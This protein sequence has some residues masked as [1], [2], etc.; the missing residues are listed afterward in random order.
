[1]SI[2]TLGNDFM[3]RFRTHHDPI[4]VLAIFRIIFPLGIILELWRD[5]P[6][7]NQHIG[8]P[9]CQPIQIF[10]DLGLPLLSPIYLKIVFTSLILSL[11]L[12]SIGFLSRLS[13]IVSLLLFFWLIGTSLGCS[14]GQDPNYTN[15]QHTIVIFNLLVMAIFPMG[16]LWRGPGHGFL[17]SER[18]AQWP[19]FLLKFN[20]IYAYF[21]GGVAKL[22]YGLDWANGYTLQ[23]HLIY[24]Y[25]HLGKEDILNLISNLH[26]LVLISSLVLLVEI[27]SPLALF[28]RK[29]AIFF[30]SGSL[31][32]HLLFYIIIDLRWMHYFGWA[33]VIYFA[34]W[35][36][37]CSRREE[38]GGG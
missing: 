11:I 34:D 13:A 29:F 36:S 8:G 20:L 14:Y 19:V 15:W 5:Y 9:L 17:L 6:G 30:I 16:S 10:Y 37:R 7:F 23:G 21:A 12:L 35:I 33:Y 3:Q 25:L 32:F 27:I 4:R 28:S 22:R 24:T 38:T 18:I 26:I 31:A 1:M 2:K